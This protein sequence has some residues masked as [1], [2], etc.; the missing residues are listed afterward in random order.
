MWQIL[1][2]T[3]L[4]M[5]TFAINDHMRKSLFLFPVVIL[6]GVSSV[7]VRSTFNPCGEPKILVPQRDQSLEQ[8]MDPTIVLSKIDPRFQFGRERVQTLPEDL[9][10]WKCLDVNQVRWIWSEEDTCASTYYFWLETGWMVI[11]SAKVRVWPNFHLTR[12]SVFSLGRVVSGIS[13]MVKDYSNYLKVF[14]VS[15]STKDILWKW[16]KKGRFLKSE[17]R[18]QKSV[19][20][21][22]T[23]HLNYYF[24]SL[25]IEDCFAL[26]TEYFGRGE[27]KISLKFFL[28]SKTKDSWT[29]NRFVL[30]ALC[31]FFC[32]VMPFISW[33][34]CLSSSFSL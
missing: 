9:C 24:Q 17:L 8:S 11:W 15:H 3:T 7:L 4:A 10:K 20:N 29:L 33:V 23:S 21:Q 14:L 13:K 34:A 6:V 1:T 5:L 26:R 12:S 19:Q 25:T 30:E 31:M 18:D 27:W 16:M 2:Y 28:S 22:P 32:S